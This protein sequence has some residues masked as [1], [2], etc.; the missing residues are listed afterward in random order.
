M[1]PREWQKPTRRI[2]VLI[3]DGEDNQSHI[4]REEAASEA[5]KAGAVVFA[6]DTELSGMSYKGAKVMQTFAKL[7]GGEYFG[8]VDKN[9]APKVFA[10]MKQ[11]MDRMYY[12]RY[13]LPDPSEG[14]VHEVE[15]KRATKEKSNLSYARKYFWNR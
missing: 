3:S 2:L 13:V 10:T 15:I 8:Q 14:A 5:L 4:T 6:I 12:L 11:M 1:G 7:T 9:G